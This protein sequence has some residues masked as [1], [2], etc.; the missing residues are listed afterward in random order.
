MN[1]TELGRKVGLSRSTLLY[2]EKL[3]LLK[4]QRG[5]NGYRVYSD[6]DRQR[7]VLLQHLKAGGLS[8]EECAA[9]LNGQLDHALLTQRADALRAEIDGKQEALKLLSALL[10]QG[11]LRQWHQ[12]LEQQAPEQHRAWLKAQG[13]TN[14]D[15]SRVALLSRD[16]HEHEAY[17]REFMQV[18]DGLERW[19]P[20]SEETTEQALADLPW[21]PGHILEVGCGHGVATLLLAQ[22]ASRVTAIDTDQAALARLQARAEAAGL[23][24]RVETHCLDMAELA[25]LNTTF[26][27]IWAEGSAYIIGVEQALASWRQYLAPGGVLVFSDLVWRTEQPAPKVA[28]FWATEYPAMSNV[29]MRLA[30]ARRQGYQVLTHR[31]M[32]QATLDAYYQP[33]AERMAALARTEKTQRVLDDL[34]AELDIYQQGQGQFGYEMFVLRKKD[35]HHALTG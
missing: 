19:G 20:G 24:E 10:G 23:G 31:D 22:H 27:V 30:Q 32:G 9:C 35:H 12:T 14:D 1:I 16:M 15:A 7:L 18:F 34:N 6:A 33:L 13:L 2:Y 11:S 5:I 28:E 25:K 29:G 4:G 26:D 17:M 21:T 8:L 3:G